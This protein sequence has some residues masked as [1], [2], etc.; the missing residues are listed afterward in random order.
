MDTIEQRL[1][2]D[3]EWAQAVVDLGDV[4]G[5]AALDGG[6]PVNVVRVGMVVDAL[7]RYLVDGGAMLYGVVDRKLLSESALTSK[8]RMV[9]SRW[10]DDGLIEVT[11]QVGD[12]VP[13][14]AELSGLP[15]VTLRPFAP[16]VTE[17]FPW[18]SD[19]SGRVLRLTVRSGVAHLSP[20]DET[21]VDADPSPTAVGRAKVPRQRTGESDGDA[22]PDQD[23][24]PDKD[25]QADEAAQDKAAPA[26]KAAAAGARR[27]A[28]A[29]LAG[30][31]P[32]RARRRPDH[33]HGGDPAPVH[34]GGAGRG[35]GPAAV[36]LPGA[37]VCGLR[38]VP[39]RR[40]AGPPAA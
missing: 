13:E 4:I 35:G 11:S 14:V 32:S 24:R 28:G 10:A 8:E 19:G 23:A 25:A 3:I 20:L 12:R 39:S 2:T 26:D 27:G 40:S 29:A 7:S 31:G 6:R 15:V 33:P 18:L 22:E 37:G 36:A 16:A 17:R 30:R 9:L 34:A 5:H 38:R 1:T 21:S